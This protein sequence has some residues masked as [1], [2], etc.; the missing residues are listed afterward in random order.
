MCYKDKILSNS[1]NSILGYFGAAILGLVLS[2]LF[3]L[4]LHGAVF[5]GLGIY[6]TYISIIIFIDI[7]CVNDVKSACEFNEFWMALET[8]IKNKI[9][10]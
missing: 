5:I 6:I 2:V 9:G 1:N 10:K 7:L 8:L 3:Q 4:T